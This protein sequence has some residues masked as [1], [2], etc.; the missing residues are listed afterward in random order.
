MQMSILEVWS[1]TGGTIII[2]SP[3]RGA[4]RCRP[5]GDLKYELEAYIPIS[6]QNLIDFSEIIVQRIAR[7]RVTPPWTY[8]NLKP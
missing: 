8:P 7:T 4:V 3:P 1:A 2:V 5:R 6:H